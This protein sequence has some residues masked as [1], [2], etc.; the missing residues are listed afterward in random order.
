MIVGSKSTF[1]RFLAA[2]SK[3]VSFFLLLNFI[4]AI[5]LEANIMDSMVEAEYIQ[6]LESGNLGSNGGSVIY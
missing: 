2:I 6:A 1:A 3:L 5:P 4:F